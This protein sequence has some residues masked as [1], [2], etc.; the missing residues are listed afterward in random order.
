MA[1]SRDDHDRNNVVLDDK[2]DT[3]ITDPKAELLP[4]L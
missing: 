2:Q 3:V 4:S 1:D